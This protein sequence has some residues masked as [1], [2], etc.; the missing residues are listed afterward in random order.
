MAAK[1]ILPCV[2]AF[3]LAIL[4]GNPI[5]KG[6]FTTFL[7]GLVLTLDAEIAVLV[8]AIAQLNIL[9]R[10]LALQIASV[11]AALNKNIADLNVLLGPLA[12]AGS[13]STLSKLLIGLESI[14][15]GKKSRGLQ[16]LLNELNRRTNLA[17][18]QDTIM[19]KKQK[20][21]NDCLDII[22]AITD[23]CG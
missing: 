2:K 4:C 6:T 12:A 20:L 14:L 11:N 10:I 22:A 1:D 9:N 18:V 3:I 21:R 8:L 16:K 19:K 7:T 5:L 13:C 17:Q 15:A 23:L